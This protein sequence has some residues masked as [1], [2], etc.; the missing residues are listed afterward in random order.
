PKS[1]GTGAPEEILQ[2]MPPGFQANVILAL[3]KMRGPEALAALDQ[4]HATETDPV[5]LERLAN[6]RREVQERL[7]R[8]KADKDTDENTGG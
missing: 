7:E 8:D 4:L 1:R 5:L 2:R 6:A 3:R